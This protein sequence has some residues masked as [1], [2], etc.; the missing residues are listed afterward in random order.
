MSGMLWRPRFDDLETERQVVLEEIAMYEDDPQDRASV[1]SDLAIFGSHPLGLPV[2]GTS[3]VVGSVSREQLLAFHSE[4]Y[5]PENIVVSAAGSLDHDALV[6]M[7]SE[8]WARGRVYGDLSTGKFEVEQSPLDFKPRTSFLQKET[9]QYHV[10]LGGRGLAR[11][12]ERRF[13]LRVLNNIFGGTTSS[14]LNQ[15]IR[16]RRGLAYSVFSFS[17]FFTQTGALGLYL[18]TRP[19]NLEEA[20]AVIANELRRCVADPAT[21]AELVRARENLKGRMVLAMESTPARMTRLGECVLTGSPIMSIDEMVE[22]IDAVG[23][24]DLKELAE[25]LFVPELL[26]VAAVGL[27][28]KVFEA[29]IASLKASS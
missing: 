15:E 19:E 8:A 7:A 28:E 20:M 6:E 12:D 9:E 25:E 4:R 11:D 1:L 29:A 21:E 22:R 2:I 26:S 17:R 27:D 23:F 13:V 14:R 24:G 3:E 16:E 5:Q 18:G 10:F